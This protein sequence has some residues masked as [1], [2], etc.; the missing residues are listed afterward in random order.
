MTIIINII[1]INIGGNPLD[2]FYRYKRPKIIAK[3][4]GYKTRIINLNEI[5]LSLNTKPDYIMQYFSY[6]K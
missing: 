5:A 1:M 6:E 3:F 4:E 2:N